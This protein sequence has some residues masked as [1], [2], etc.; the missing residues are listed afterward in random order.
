MLSGRVK[1]SE[2]E[3]AKSDDCL[4]SD[5]L[6]VNTFQIFRGQ[7]SNANQAVESLYFVLSK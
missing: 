2:T 5:S 3:A 7:M 6:R 4:A 1:G